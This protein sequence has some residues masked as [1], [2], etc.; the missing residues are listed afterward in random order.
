MEI[1]TSI[2]YCNVLSSF[3]CKLDFN[4]FHHSHAH[5]YFVLLPLFQFDSLVWARSWLL[6]IYGALHAHKEFCNFNSAEWN[7]NGT[8]TDTATAPH[9][10]CQNGRHNWIFPFQLKIR[11]YASL[12]IFHC[13]KYCFL[14][15]I[16]FDSRA[17]KPNLLIRKEATTPTNA[18]C[19][20]AQPFK[21]NT[22]NCAEMKHSK[23]RNSFRWLLF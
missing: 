2:N 19:H 9:T 23:K 4:W 13:S 5:A 20:T 11:F 17:K 10:A 1:I 21:C 6:L 14:E 15:K 18:K 7:K 22:I 12:F 16:F 3:S 8:A